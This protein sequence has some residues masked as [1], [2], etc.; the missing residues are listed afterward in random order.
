MTMAAHLTKEQWTAIEERLR[1][2]RVRL[3]NRGITFG[4]L[5]LVLWAMILA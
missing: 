5:V 1:I 4:V 3:R 2:E